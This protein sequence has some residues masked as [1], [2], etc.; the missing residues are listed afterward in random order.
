MKTIGLIGGMSWES[1]ASYYQ[2]INQGIK[3]QLGGLHSAKMVLVSIDFAE[4]EQ[5]QH[6]GD[7]QK[8]ADILADAAK[9]LEAAGAD[10]FLI[11]TNTMH[12]VADKVCQ[13]VSIP[14]LHIADAT[15]HQLAVDQ[16]NKVALLGTKFTMQ[17]D[18]YKNRIQEHFAIEVITPNSEEQKIVHQVIYQ[19]LCLGKVS[20]KSRQQYLAIIDNLANQGAQ[21]VILGCTEIG[22]LIQQKHTPMPLYDT[23]AIHAAAAVTYSL[24]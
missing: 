22:L 18:F 19:E 11:C 23:T 2:L 1:T 3:Q 6:Q 21:A 8:T 17:Q 16:T 9:S 5:L 15:G 4:I 10:F 7:W 13:A 20:V 24:K 12:K 14:L